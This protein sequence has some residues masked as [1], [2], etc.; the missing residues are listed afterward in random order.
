MPTCVLPPTSYPPM[1]TCWS[2]AAHS[3]FTSVAPPLPARIIDAHDPA[4]PLP[5]TAPAAYSSESAAVSV[6]TASSFESMR[7]ALEGSLA[8]DAH[9]STTRVDSVAAEEVDAPELPRTTARVES[10]LV[11]PTPRGR[12]A[13]SS[14]DGSGKKRT[15]PSSN[16][17]SRE[18]SFNKRRTPRQLLVGTNCNNSGSDDVSPSPADL[19]IFS[20]PPGGVYLLSGDT[21]RDASPAMQRARS[22]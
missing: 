17:C 8:A 12:S 22:R 10:A 15:P 3:L 16:E 19:T 1:A 6:P 2:L 21:S 20:K 13:S 11:H 9:D 5:P 18:G 7:A 14:R 4:I